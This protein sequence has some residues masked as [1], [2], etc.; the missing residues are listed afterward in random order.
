MLKILQKAVKVAANG[1]VML[2]DGVI[3]AYTALVIITAHW[4]YSQGDDGQI[5]RALVIYRPGIVNYL[6]L[7]DE[8]PE[9]VW[10]F[11]L[12]KEFAITPWRPFEEPF[13]ETED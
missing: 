7:D 8:T 11:T 9:A 5:Y 10:H 4:G 6:L 3:A 1:V 13:N 12:F 2:F